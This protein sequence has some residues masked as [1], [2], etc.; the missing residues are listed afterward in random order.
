MAEVVSRPHAARVCGPCKLGKRACNKLLPTCSYCQRW[1]I[2][3]THIIRITTN[4]DILRLGR[5]CYYNMDLSLAGDRKA[6]QG[7][8]RICP[9]PGGMRD[10]S[11]SIRQQQ[12]LSF[13]LMESQHDS[14][15][16]SD[17]RLVQQRAKPR[18]FR[19]RRRPVTVCQH[20][21]YLRKKCSRELPNCSYCQR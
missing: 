17:N 10:V 7:T 5:P 19:K 9:L 21:R 8:R 6:S 18:Q 11:L 13:T 20:C 15:G 2:N 12:P 1:N 14:P 16:C 4:S 3:I